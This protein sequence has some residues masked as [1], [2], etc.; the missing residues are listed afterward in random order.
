LIAL[1]PLFELAHC[2]GDALLADL[3]AAV[4]VAV[5]DV[6]CAHQCFLTCTMPAVSPPRNWCA[7]P[8][9]N[10]SIMEYMF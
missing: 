4:N 10:S 8:A 9:S 7:S 6:R 5:L 2:T 1:L 3:H